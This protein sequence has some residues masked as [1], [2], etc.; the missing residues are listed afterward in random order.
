MC[1]RCS[2]GIKLSVFVCDIYFLSVSNVNAS[3]F[4]AENLYG[5]TRL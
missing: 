1:D 3:K 4:V 2:L 5:V